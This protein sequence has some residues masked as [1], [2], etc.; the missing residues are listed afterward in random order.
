MQNRRI[1]EVIR[2]DRFLAPTALLCSEP[3]ADKCHRRLVV[4]I[5]EETWLGQGH[6][7]QIRHLVSEK[8]KATAAH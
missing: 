5:L 7:V 1:A 3:A 6:A 4:E 2:P 8:Q